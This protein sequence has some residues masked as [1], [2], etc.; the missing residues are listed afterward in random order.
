M[1][2]SDN[3]RDTGAKNDDSYNNKSSDN[4]NTHEPEIEIPQPS[5]ATPTFP[6][7]MPV[8]PR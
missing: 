5:I 6:T 3:N 4:D 7:E 8:L 1:K 2:Q